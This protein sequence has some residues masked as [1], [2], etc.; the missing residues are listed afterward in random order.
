MGQELGDQGEKQEIVW[1]VERTE[2][3]FHAEWVGKPV[4]DVK[5]KNDLI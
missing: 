1:E 5:Q 4:E 2:F 3:G